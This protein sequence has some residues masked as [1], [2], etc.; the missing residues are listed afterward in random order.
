MSRL[1]KGIYHEDGPDDRLRFK[2]TLLQQDP[3]KKGSYIAQFDAL[4][5]PE[6]HGWHSFPKDLFVNVEE[7]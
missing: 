7:L 5:L 4:Y 6:S 3:E 2:S 1:K